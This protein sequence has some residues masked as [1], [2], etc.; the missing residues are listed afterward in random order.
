MTFCEKKLAVLLLCLIISAGLTSC[1]N[2]YSNCENTDSVSYTVISTT[3]ETVN[4]TTA[5]IQNT[6]IVNTNTGKFHCPDCHSVEQMN[7]NNKRKY[8]DDRDDLISDGYKPC[9]RCNP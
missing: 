1:K 6:Y 4:E 9:K 8:V 7:E 5:A 2:N 3:A